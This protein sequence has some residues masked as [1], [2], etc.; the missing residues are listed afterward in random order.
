MKEDISYR[1]CELYDG[2]LCSS[3]EGCCVDAEIGCVYM[4]SFKEEH[5]YLVDFESKWLGTLQGTR[6]ARKRG[7]R[8]FDKDGSFIGLLDEGKVAIWYVGI[9]TLKRCSLS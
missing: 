9:D 3:K 1:K 6:Y 2:K 4:H 7:W 8:V 5:G